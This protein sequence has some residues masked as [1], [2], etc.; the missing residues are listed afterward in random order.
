MDLVSEDNLEATEKGAQLERVV[1][2][3]LLERKEDRVFR[4][5]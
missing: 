2:L 5:P 1:V 4:D 3:V